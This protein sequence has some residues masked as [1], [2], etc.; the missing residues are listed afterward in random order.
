[1]QP[2]ISKPTG[3]DQ[4]RLQGEAAALFYMIKRCGF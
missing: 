4:K 1:M 3:K 2:I